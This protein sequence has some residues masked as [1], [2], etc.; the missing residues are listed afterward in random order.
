MQAIRAAFETRKQEGAAA[1][2]TFVT[3]G[4]P[5]KDDTVPILLAMQAGGAD[6]IELGIPFS[7]PI[8]D[9]PV[10]QEANTIA[11]NNDID[12]PTVLGQLRE[13][14]SKGLTVPVILMGYYNPL[15]AYDEEKSIH[16][17]KEAGANGFVVV[18]LPPEEAVSFREKC[19]KADLAYVPLIAPSTT[20]SRIKFLASIADT[21]IYLVSKMG[22]TGSSDNVALNSE[23]PNIISR[24]R[25][26]ATVPIAVGF[27]VANRSHYE[28]AC[29]AGA[30]GV[31]VGSRIIKVIQ[32]AAP[33]KLPEVLQD[34]CQQMSRRGDP[35]KS[36]TTPSDVPRASPQKD[37]PPAVNAP[38]DAGVLPARFGQFGGQYVPEALFDCLA[39]LEQAHKAAMDDPEFWK[40]LQSHYGYMNRPSRLYLAENLTKDAGG[41][42]IW[43]KREDLN[44]TGSHKINNAI[45]QIL[46]ARRIGKTRIIAETG[47]GQHGVATATVCAKFGMECIIYMGEEDV[48]RQALNVFRIQMLGAKVIPVSSG[49]RTLKDAVNEAL[50]DWVTNLATTHYLVGSAIGPH[51][52]PTLVRDFQKVI[53]QEIKQQLQELRGKLPDAVVACVGGGSNAIGTFYDFIPDKSVRL[54]G[55]EAGGEGLD[56]DR[57]SATLSK[58]QPGVLHG[59]RTYILQSSS[60]QIIE[61]HSISAGL[62]YPGVGPE[63]AWLKDS[64]RAE[65]VVATDEEALRGFRMLTQREGIIP[66][67][68][69]SH[70]IWEAVKIAKTMPKGSDLVVCLSGRGDKDVEQISEL[71]PKWADKLD[72]HISQ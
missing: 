55:V 57:H 72:W 30:D 26:Y 33:E 4:F 23:L 1:L 42:N 67:L 32:G 10:I 22:T 56:G 8:A 70:A 5:R 29:Q 60:G 2:V 53:G 44:H 38:A 21:F 49:S 59:V 20:L 69:S 24:V 34:Y 14:R 35:V 37:S 16:D 62:D 51:P 65:Y 25:E 28:I 45:G 63:H 48:R 6:I 31:V 54:V 58:G 27:G 7:D 50:R 64:G 47:A 36:Q 68:E 43:L 15:L 52:F 39:E 71:L 61:T 66:A 13:A 12:Y 9:G 40:E 3:A 19:A 46:L 41:A 11:L 17:A 18:D